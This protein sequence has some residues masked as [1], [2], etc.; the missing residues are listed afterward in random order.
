MHGSLDVL[1]SYVELLP[2]DRNVYIELAKGGLGDINES[3][4]IDAH[5]FG[6]KVVGFGVKPTAKANSLARDRGVELFS[7][8]VI[9]EVFDNVLA[10]IREKL[11]LVTTQN[12]VGSG[13]VLQGISLRGAKQEFVAAG[14][15]VQSRLAFSCCCML[16]FCRCVLCRK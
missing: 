3:D 8:Q 7:S 9:Y 2:S 15:E 14:V 6:A 11:P 4:V 12:V 16:S 13:E 10:A 1:R 5:T